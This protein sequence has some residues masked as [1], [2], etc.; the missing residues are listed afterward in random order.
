[1]VTEKKAMTSTTL[2]I[3]TQGQQATILEIRGGRSIRSRLSGQGLHP[4]DHIRV[5]QSSHLGGPIVIE[6]HDVTTAIGRGMASAVEVE[7]IR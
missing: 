2:E 1:M 4:G 6:I 5:V 3:L 7:V